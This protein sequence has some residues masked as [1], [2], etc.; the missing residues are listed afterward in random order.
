MLKTILGLYEDR[1]R[2]CKVVDALLKAGVHDA[3]ISLVAPAVEERQVESKTSH[4]RSTAAP[5]DAPSLQQTDSLDLALPR[6]DVCVLPGLG[7][8]V[9]AGPIGRWLAHNT[10]GD[11][12]LATLAEWGVGPEEI[13][14]YAEGVRRGGA[15]VAVKASEA[16][17]DGVLNVMDS[18]DPVDIDR[19]AQ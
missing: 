12:L 8:V 11:G 6:L 10:V 2:L 19:W 4:W 5:V 9:T 7:P 18:H 15:L 13:E 3:N 17:V 14:F 16:T 1:D